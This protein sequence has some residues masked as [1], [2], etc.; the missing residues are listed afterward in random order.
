MPSTSI[1]RKSYVRSIRG[2]AFEDQAGNEYTYRIVGPDEFDPKQG[3]IS[4][5]SPMGK[6]LLGKMLDDEFELCIDTG[7]GSTARTYII[8]EIWYKARD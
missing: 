4:M 1:A 6:A 2:Y 5:D 3:Y 7:E 8:N